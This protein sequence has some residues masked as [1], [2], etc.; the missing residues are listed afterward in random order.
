MR[1]MMMHKHD[2]HTE[3]GLPPPPELIQKMGAFIGE[4]AKAG[5]FVTGAGLGATKTR[6][7][8]VFRN[9]RCTSQRGPYRGERELPIGLALAAAA[10]EA[11]RYERRDDGAV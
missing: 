6:T 2:A 9:G 4:H 10:E 8:L 5:R 11:V 7:R 1:F 3:A